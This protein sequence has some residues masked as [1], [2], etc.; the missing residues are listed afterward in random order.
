MELNKLKNEV[1]AKSAQL[2]QLDKQVEDYKAKLQ[3]V[4]E[5]ESPL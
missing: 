5:N 3:K 4:G 2:Q 1:A